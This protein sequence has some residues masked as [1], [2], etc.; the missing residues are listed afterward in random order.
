MKNIY[1][2]LAMVL[3]TFALFAL[4]ATSQTTV[5]YKIIDANDDLEERLAGVGDPIGSVDATSSDLEIGTETAGEPQ[6]IGLIFRAVA[7]PKGATITNA[8]VQ[9]TCDEADSQVLPP[10][11]IGGEKSANAVAPYSVTDFCISSRPKTTAAVS[12][13]PPAW[14][15]VDVR[16]ANERTPDIKTIVQEIVNQ[17]GWASGNNLAI[18]IWTDDL[19]KEHRT[20]EAFEGDAAQVAELFITYT[21]GVGVE[22]INASNG[23]VYPNPA[24]GKF[25]IKNPSSGNFDYTVYNLIG[26]KVTSREDLSGS[27]TEVDMSK[28]AKGLYVVEVK[29]AGGSVKNKLFLK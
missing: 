1:K 20:A 26:K 11:T 15:T 28:S 14:E 10:L 5:S 16:T 22:K 25:T 27:S 29:T 23:L 9:F 12:W 24:E 3:T 17:T 6:I 8:Y 4:V 2:K 21:A 13:V 7:V 19:V 18:M